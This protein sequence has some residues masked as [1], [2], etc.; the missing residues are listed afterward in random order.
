[1]KSKKI[2]Q[3]LNLII[4]RITWNYG[5]KEVF[6]IG[7]FTNW[8]YM[9]KLHEVV[10]GQTPVFEISMV[11]YKYLE[12]IIFQYVKAG[13]YYYYFLVDGQIRFA[14][15]QPSNIGKQQ[16]IVNFINIDNYM[17]AKAEEA[18]ED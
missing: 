3:R 5:G 10:I 13:L 9:I 4:V 15:D 12:S 17:I 11:R 6:I 16:Q 2:Y 14:P 7:S 18:R 1:M 8:D